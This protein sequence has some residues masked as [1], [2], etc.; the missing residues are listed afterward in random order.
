MGQN[1]TPDR[2]AI[3]TNSSLM[4][5]KFFMDY[6]INPISYFVVDFHFND[7]EIVYFYSW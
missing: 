3:S 6:I 7:F 2:T 5:S 4:I 1:Q